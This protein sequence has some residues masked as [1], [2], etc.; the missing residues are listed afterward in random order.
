[1]T[2][3]S[4]TLA[5][6]LEDILARLKEKA[7]VAPIVDPPPCGCE[8]SGYSV[9]NKD[10]TWEF[11]LCGCKLRCDCLHGFTYE[12]DTEGYEYA[13]DCP[14]CSGARRTVDVLNS[15]NLPYQHDPRSA[16]PRGKVQ[17]VVFGLLRKWVQ[18]YTDGAVG[19]TL[20]G[21]PGVGKSFVL[22]ATLR[23]L[24]EQYR[25]RASYTHVPSLLRTQRQAMDAPEQSADNRLSSLAQVPVLGI[26]EL[27]DLRTDWQREVMA[28]LLSARYDAGRTTLITTNLCEDESMR[29]F[30]AG[31][32]DE[33]SIHAGGRII[34][35]L[36]QWAPIVT[37]DGQDQRR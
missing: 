21:P 31:R 11:V 33:R 25:V 23:A 27:S 18:K 32:V 20:S 35:R 22:V 34:S 5:D 36:A 26:D 16:K 15:A 37:I 3:P 12:R 24:V 1:M 28:E 13:R 9:R 30:S 29:L 7:S 8:G 2:M 14:R 19:M 4:E 17:K 6:S 10:G